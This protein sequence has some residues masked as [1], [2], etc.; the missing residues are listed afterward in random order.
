[1]ICNNRILFKIK[2][3]T[4]EIILHYIFIYAYNK[5]QEEE[6]NLWLINLL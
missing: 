5:L 3:L 2:G 4:N 6:A 1:M